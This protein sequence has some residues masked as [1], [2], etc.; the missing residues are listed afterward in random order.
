MSLI[1]RGCKSKGGE[2]RW[3]RK[4]IKRT[5][6]WQSRLDY[7]R[8]LSPLKCYWPSRQLAGLAA[9]SDF[10]GENDPSGASSAAMTYWIF[11][12]I[13]R[14]AISSIN[15]RVN[16]G[17]WNNMHHH[18]EPLECNPR[19]MGN[20]LIKWKLYDMENRL[21]ATHFATIA[22][23]LEISLLCTSSH[24]ISWY[25]LPPRPI[26][27]HQWAAKW[28]WRCKHKSDFVSTIASLFNM[29]W[30]SAHDRRGKNRYW[31]WVAAEM[32]A[33]SAEIDTYESS[34]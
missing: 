32:C 5:N 30:K 15:H 10:T 11:Y 27:A 1:R 28:H 7:F 29:K 25:T 34:C 20:R 9:S 23:I 6:F 21:F 24:R 4:S 14:N 33:S 19:T 17:P 3:T 2:A 12:Q 22:L 18:G 31:E 16:R 13:T 26:T 8:S